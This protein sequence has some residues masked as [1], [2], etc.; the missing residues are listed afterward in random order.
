M[1]FLVSIVVVVA[2]RPLSSVRYTEYR[3]SR[4]Q[5]GEETSHRKWKKGLPRSLTRPQD[6]LSIRT[7]SPNR[8]LFSPPPSPTHHQSCK[9]SLPPS[10]PTN[11]L[12][13]TPRVS[14]QR[15]NRTNTHTKACGHS[16]CTSRCFV[17]TD[18]RTHTHGWSLPSCLMRLQQQVAATPLAGSRDHSVF[19]RS[20]QPQVL[21]TFCFL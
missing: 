20:S 11:R 1:P 5:L 9:T 7:S 15:N 14:C 12:N 18:A 19:M 16:V 3:G 21:L 13:Q 17:V 4:T 2:P 10:R 8:P 6:C